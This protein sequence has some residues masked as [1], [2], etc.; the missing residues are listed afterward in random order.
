MTRSDHESALIVFL[1]AFVICFVLHL[2]NARARAKSASPL[3]S[4]SADVFLETSD[5]EISG[6]QIYQLQENICSS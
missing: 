5:D 2:Q 1:K 6:K 3:R 4:A